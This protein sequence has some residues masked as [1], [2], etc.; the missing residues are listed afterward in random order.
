MKKI[1]EFALAHHLQI[2][3]HENISLINNF[4]RLIRSNPKKI[5]IFEAGDFNP[6]RS[7]QKLPCSCGGGEGLGAYHWDGKITWSD[8]EIWFPCENRDHNN[9]G[10]FIWILNLQTKQSHQIQIEEDRQ[11]S[12]KWDDIILDIEHLSE[13]VCEE[14]TNIWLHKWVQP[15]KEIP[16]KM[17]SYKK[18]REMTTIYTENHVVEERDLY[19][20]L[21]ER[22]KEYRKQQKE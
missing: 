5:N 20:V 4:S 8:I 1:Y 6:C 19:D 13:K 21:E 18:R 7:L 22:V 15:L 2:V 3:D 17:I 16:V 14:Q 12:N 9:C 11:I 10:K